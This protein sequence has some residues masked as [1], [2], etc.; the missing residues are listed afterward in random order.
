MTQQF[1]SINVLELSMG[2]HLFISLKVRGL[3]INLRVIKDMINKK[4]NMFLPISN[5][6]YKA[7]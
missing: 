2:K 5:V 6:E 1:G 4:E 7:T 3:F